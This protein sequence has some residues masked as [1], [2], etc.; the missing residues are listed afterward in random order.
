MSEFSVFV[1]SLF[2]KGSIPLGFITSPKVSDFYLKSVDDWASKKHF[3]KY[4]RYADD[5]LFSTSKENISLEKTEMYFKR[6]I[7]QKGLTINQNKKIIKHLKK[8]GD[9]IKFLGICIVRK[10]GKNVI[11]VSKSYI[12]EVTKECY[13]TSPDKLSS[14]ERIMGKIRYI[15]NIS[16]SSYIQLLRGLMNNKDVYEAVSIAIE[17]SILYLQEKHQVK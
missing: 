13:S 2:Y 14:N 15:K 4:S 17:H 5:I 16:E 6:I 8:E 11:K 3:V 12:K 7:K 1:K 9:Y 10:N